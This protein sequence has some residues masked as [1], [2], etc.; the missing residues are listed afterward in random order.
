MSG[1][2]RLP[3]QTDNFVPFKDGVQTQQDHRPAAV[4]H[5]AAVAGLIDCRRL[6]NLA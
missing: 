5:G 3:A 6:R 1:R 4:T 2:R